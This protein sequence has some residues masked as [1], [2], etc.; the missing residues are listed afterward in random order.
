MNLSETHGQ[1][2]KV[3]KEGVAIK[4]ISKTKKLTSPASNCQRS[5]CYDRMFSKNVENGH[6]SWKNCHKLSIFTKNVNKD[7]YAENSLF[8]QI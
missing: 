6:F 2:G 1:V 7:I 3:L 5:Q 8:T 4:S